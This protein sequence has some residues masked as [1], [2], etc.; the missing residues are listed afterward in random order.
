MVFFSVC[1]SL[2]QHDC[3]NPIHDG[4][5]PLSYSEEVVHASGA[6]PADDS[7]LKLL[8]EMQASESQVLGDTQRD[9]GVT[10]S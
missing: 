10:H 5:K 4:F 2:M 3:L 9:A 6:E 8:T 1:V 7:I